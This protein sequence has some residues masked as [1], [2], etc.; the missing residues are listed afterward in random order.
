METDNKCDFRFTNGLFERIFNDYSA[1][2]LVYAKHYVAS[3]D[4]AEDIVHDVFVNFWE[5]KGSIDHEKIKSY[6]FA[7]TRNSCLN[8]LSRLK[9]RTKYQTDIIREGKPPGAFE[10]DFYVP[11]EIRAIIDAAINKLP[12]QR[13]KVFIM[14]R[15]EH[16]TFAEIGVELGISPKTVDKHIE[17]ALKDLRAG[18]S[19]YLYCL[20]CTGIFTYSFTYTVIFTKPFAI[21]ALCHPTNK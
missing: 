7:S 11:A 5:K 20:L 12:E 4:V 3:H 8:H 18:L 6:L 21:F 10:E 1:G 15:F 16:K 17:L 2:L 19:K 9:M 13:R 14:H